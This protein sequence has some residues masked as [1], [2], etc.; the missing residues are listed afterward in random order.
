MTKLT[1]EQQRSL[2]VLWERSS[3]G[4]KGYIEF[5][6]RIHMAF[7]D[8]CAM[9]HWCGMWVGIEEDGYRHT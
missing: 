7:N 8:S 2:K 5:R 3:D 4:A 6:R 9:I 1:K